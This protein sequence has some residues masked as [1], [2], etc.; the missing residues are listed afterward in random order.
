[1]QY[2]D[3]LG[4][5]RLSYSDLDLN[6]AIN[7][8]TEIIEESN[9][10]PFGLQQKG[11]NNNVSP[12]GNALAQ[13]FKYNGIELE[14]SLDLNLYEMDLRQYDPAIARWTSIDPVTHFNFSTY[15]AFDNNPVFW[16]DP[17]GADAETDDLIN[18]AWN[19]TEDGTNAS[20]DNN[21]DCEC[22]CPGKPPCAEKKDVKDMSAGEFYAMAYNGASRTAY[23]NGNDPYNPTDSDIA[24]NEKEKAEAAGELV[25]FLVGEWA[26]AK[27]LQGGSYVYRF[28]KFK[29]VFSSTMSVSVKDKLAHYLLNLD[30]ATGGSKAVF[31]KDA[32]GFTLD[33]ADDLAKQIVFNNKKAI[34]TEV[35]KYGTKYSQNIAIK[36]ANGR[37][38]DVTFGWIKNKE[39]LV[40]L[41]TG[42]PAK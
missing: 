42:Y 15:T 25:L 27:V 33:N 14:E 5:V 39:G 17:S 38:V 4:S 19:D 36:G 34:A 41:V 20:Y 26:F 23:L 6:G 29:S 2:K 16:A 31:F 37:V 12:S 30:H 3:H 7:P 24:Q 18:Q 40:R 22:G 21:G 10:Y 32:L 28:V 35:T 9:Y 1:Y 13:Q 11:Y 8:N